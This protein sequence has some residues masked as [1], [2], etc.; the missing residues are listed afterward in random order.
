M[1]T[2]GDIIVLE[3]MPYKNT[4]LI[5]INKKRRPFL[6]VAHDDECYYLLKLSSA[7]SNEKCEF[8]KIQIRTP[9]HELYVDLKAIYKKSICWLDS[10]EHID[11]NDY[12]AVLSRLMEYQKIKKSD[13]AYLPIQANI[14]MQIEGLSSNNVNSSYKKSRSK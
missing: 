1:V 14:R 10:I 7:K 3:Y 11:K 12:I 9:G 4:G 8:S 2:T 13:D 6:V 5:D